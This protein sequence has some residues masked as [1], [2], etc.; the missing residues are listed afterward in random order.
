M[1]NSNLCGLSVL[2]TKSIKVIWITKNLREN[3]KNV[4][5]NGLTFLFS[6][7]H[8]GTASILDSIHKNVFI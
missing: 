7:I 5:S 3:L 6:F 4:R 1:D 8:C 2:C